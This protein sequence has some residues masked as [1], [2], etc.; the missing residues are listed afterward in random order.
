[1][2]LNTILE[3]ELLFLLVLFSISQGSKEQT[4]VKKPELI[5]NSFEVIHLDEIEN[6]FIL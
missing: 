3:R 5:V 1:M 2:K 6:R 4:I